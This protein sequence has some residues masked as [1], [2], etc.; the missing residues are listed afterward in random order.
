M[1]NTSLQATSWVGGDYR[2]SV[3]GRGE[4]NQGDGGVRV[5][6]EAI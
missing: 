6:D 4:R 2:G 3:A 5:K 1:D